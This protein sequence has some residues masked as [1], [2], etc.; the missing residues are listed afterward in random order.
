[1]EKYRTE[2]LD[3]DLFKVLS[4]PIFAEGERMLP[5]G[6][7]VKWTRKDLE[8]VVKR[9]KAADYRPP[10]FVGHADGETRSQG[11]RPAL[12][13]LSDIRI[14]EFREGGK[15]KCGLVADF[16]NVSKDIV[17]A[18]E[19]DRYPGRSIEIG[20][21]TRRVYGLA[22]LGRTAAHYELPQRSLSEEHDVVQTF[23]FNF[24][25]EAYAMNPPPSPAPAAQPQTAPQA[26]PAQPGQDPMQILQQIAKLLQP[27]MAGAQQPAPQAAPAAPA[28]APAQGSA[29]KYSANTDETVTETETD[30]SDES[31]RI[32]EL[33][34]KIELQALKIQSYQAKI[35]ELESE[36]QT[37]SE[38]AENQ[39]F[40]ATIATLAKEGYAVDEARFAEH[41]SKFS[42]EDA[43][44]IVRAGPK[45]PVKT[46]VPSNETRQEV[47]ALN[48]KADKG[49][50]A[51]LDFSQ[52]GA[53]SPELQKYALQG[54]KYWDEIDPQGAKITYGSRDE[55][56]ARHVKY[57]ML[58]NLS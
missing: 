28:P 10:I 40:K 46:A 15:V 52:Y 7:K 20:D 33:E 12:G 51:G 35:K 56:I 31:A 50:A 47:A 1:M 19:T 3:N 22:L 2:A 9:F 8:E 13:V 16:M 11:D 45:A 29:S 53:T 43:A 57:K 30:V 41:V 36:G 55:C 5:N 42:L 26:A 38:E 23:S 37:A 32:A 17:D 14:A 34:R 25:T 58:H 6:E 44:D 24:E 39:K 49:E 54:A 21:K 4:V 27:M 48:P 18:L